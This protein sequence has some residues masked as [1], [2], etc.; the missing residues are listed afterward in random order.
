MKAQILQVTKPR[1]HRAADGL[2]VEGSIATA[3]SFGFHSQQGQTAL[4]TL[5]YIEYGEMSGYF[6]NIRNT[7]T[8][9]GMGGIIVAEARHTITLRRSQYV[10]LDS[11]Y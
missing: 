9:K 2:R 3:R 7:M 5:L 10:D 8:K 6:P 11:H 1:T 4:L